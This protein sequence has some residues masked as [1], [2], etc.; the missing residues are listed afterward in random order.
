MK[1]ITPLTILA[2]TCIAA[3]IAQATPTVEFQTDS[4]LFSCD[5][6]SSDGRYVCGNARPERVLS[7]RH[8]HLGHPDRLNHA[9]EHRREGRR[10]HHRGRVDRRR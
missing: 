10:R 1:R 7:R 5:N 6:M 4:M 2:G 8:L 3:Q 9:P